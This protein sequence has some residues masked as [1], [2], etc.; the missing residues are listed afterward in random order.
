MLSLIEIQTN[1]LLSLL[2][3]EVENKYGDELLKTK[4]YLKRQKEKNIT[5]YD[6][7]MSWKLFDNLQTIK[8][9]AILMISFKHQTF[10]ESS[11]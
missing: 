3:D 6:A 7:H 1:G 11:T 8:L 9:I 5:L 10:I 2:T 4:T